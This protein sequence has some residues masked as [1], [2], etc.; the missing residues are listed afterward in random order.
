MATWLASDELDFHGATAVASGWLRRARRLLAPLESGPDHGWLA[1][2]E[3]YLAHASGDAGAARA[4]ATSA[5][6]IGREYRVVDLEMLGLALEGAALVS[7]ARIDEGMAC[8]DEAT[9]MAVEGDAAIPISSAWTCCFLV[10]A[11]MKVLDL[12]RAVEWCDRIDRFAERYG[13]RYMLAFCR[14][15]YGSV[16]LAR[17]RWSDAEAMLVAAVDDFTHSRPAWVGGPLSEL[18]ELRRR[19]GRADEAADLLERA[20][21]SRTA[22]LCRARLALDRG[23]TLQAVEL[24]ELLLRRLPEAN[25]LDR[26]PALELLVRARAARGELDEA[27]ESL[28][29]L[30]AIAHRI[31]T[32]HLRASLDLTEGRLA[33]ARGDHAMGRTMF[34]DAADRFEHAGTPFDAAQARIELAASLAALGRSD[35][36]EREHARALRALD[37][38]GLEAGDADDVPLAQ[39]TARERDVLG[40]LVE[41]MTNRQIAERLVISEHT[42]HRHVSNILRK[43]DA[44]S[45]TAVAA[46]AARAGVLGTSS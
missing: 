40:L 11:C 45:R 43:L 23:D 5:A 20:G 34:E 7:S 28:A 35:D 8:L 39:L 32:P 24:L 3:G 9:T 12:E 1:F 22:Q 15:E 44:P 30:R 14:A 27:D 31:G 19:Q 6:E 25:D 29:A 46:R 36:A 4:L 10:S 18:A 26:A 2:H 17:G 38:I 16:D 41:G 13:S 42:V 37:A 33:V 21:A